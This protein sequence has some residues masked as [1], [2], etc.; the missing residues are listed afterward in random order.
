[1]NSRV[2]ALKALDMKVVTQLPLY[3]TDVVI[4]E[5]HIHIPDDIKNIFQEALNLL[6]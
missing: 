3:K 1:M 6:K 4:K 2:Q 5:D